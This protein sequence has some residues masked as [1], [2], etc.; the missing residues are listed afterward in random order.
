M[1]E[2][3]PDRPLDQKTIQGA[4][5]VQ[6]VAADVFLIHDTAVNR[7]LIREGRDL[8]LVDAGYPND[9]PALIAAVEQ[10]GH[11]VEDIRAVLLTHSHVDHLGALPEL[12]ER[13]GAVVYAHPLELPIVHGEVREQASTWDIVRRCWRPRVAH[14]ALMVARAGARTRPRVCEAVPFP[15]AGALDVPGRPRPIHCPGHTSGHT[16]YEVPE[17]GVLVTGDAL[18]TGHPLSART[19]P[20]VLPAYF[21]HDAQENLGSLGVLSDIDA[22]TLVP[23][24]G[25]VWHGSMGVAVA[26]ARIPT[27]TRAERRGAPSR[28]VE[29]P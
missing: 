10:L 16:A 2:L 6:Q 26:L 8:T 20:Q 9:L 28:G 18:I 14:W 7:I 29:Q 24:H 15:T 5:R 13:V 11:N 19:G 12:L 23:G 4:P 3:A 17:Q 27:A 25:P 1:D 21:A 22:N